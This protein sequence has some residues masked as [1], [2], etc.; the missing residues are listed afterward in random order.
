MVENMW[1][2][3][4]GWGLLPRCVFILRKVAPR[5]GVSAGF[6]L[7]ESV[8]GED[9]R[10]S[11]RSGLSP[12]PATCGVFFLYE[13]HDILH[14]CVSRPASINQPHPNACF[15][16]LIHY[17]KVLICI[18]KIFGQNMAWI[19][20]TF[21][22]SGWTRQLLTS[23]NFVKEKKLIENLQCTTLPHS[24]ILTLACVGLEGPI[25]AG[26]RSSL[27][28]CSLGRPIIYQSKR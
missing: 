19:L 18:C 6:T 24:F 11:P 9:R 22:D 5:F 12:L 25:S 16:W 2:L 10:E 23:L 8:R 27:Y 4:L 26:Q 21:S 1:L 7:A 17:L 28:F 20:V 15:L 3:D 13:P 14:S